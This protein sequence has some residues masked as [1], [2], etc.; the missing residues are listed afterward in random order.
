MPE[1]TVITDA[2]RPAEASVDGG[3][4][5]VPPDSLPVVLGWSLKAEGLCRDDVC[6]PTGTATV[7]VGDKV[8]LGA[9]ASCLGRPAVF[10]AESGIAAIALDAEA[11][12]LALDA[13][14]APPFTLNDLDGAPH[15]FSEW[16]GRKRLLIAFSSW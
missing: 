3:R 8:D 14:H 2:A 9:V 5:L 13:L 11:R 6:V 16:S 12:H 10:D 4:W 7:R 15:S 1:V